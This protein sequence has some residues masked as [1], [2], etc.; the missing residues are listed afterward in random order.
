MANEQKLPFLQSLGIN[1]KNA[2][3]SAIFFAAGVMFMLPVIILF[4]WSS[5]FDSDDPSF[6]LLIFALSLLSLL[7]SAFCFLLGLRA[8][9]IGRRRKS[10]IGIFLN[11]LGLLLS[12]LVLL[13]YVSLVAF[14]IFTL[15][16]RLRGLT[17]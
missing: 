15:I 12:S 6:A 8:A 14:L 3:V 7:L 2:K 17:G 9:L 4:D 16:L 5:F 10:K 1:I 13:P 11:S